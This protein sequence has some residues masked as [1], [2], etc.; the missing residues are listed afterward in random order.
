MFAY[1]RIVACL[2]LCAVFSLTSE[3]ASRVS[4]CVR[5]EV[6]WQLGNA[7]PANNDILLYLPNKSGKSSELKTALFARDGKQVSRE[8]AGK[9]LE[10]RFQSDEGNGASPVA[11]LLEKFI[12]T[13]RGRDLLSGYHP[14]FHLGPSRANVSVRDVSLQVSS[15]QTEVSAVIDLLEVQNA[16]SRVD[17]ISKGVGGLSLPAVSAKSVSPI[18]VRVPV[19]VDVSSEGKVG[20]QFHELPH[21][22]VSNLSVEMDGAK[23]PTEKVFEFLHE[24]GAVSKVRTQLLD[25]LNTQVAQQLSREAK[26]SAQVVHP[27]TGAPLLKVEISP[28]SLTADSKGLTAGIRARINP[29]EKV[30]ARSIAK[31][32]GSSAKFHCP[33]GGANGCPEYDGA[34][35]VNQ[36]L[37]QNLIG[38]LY[39]SGAMSGLKAGDRTVSL[40][41]P[42]KI[43]YLSS[44]GVESAETSDHAAAY[45]K[46]GLRVRPDHLSGLEGMVLNQNFSIRT[47]VSL[48]AAPSKDGKGIEV[49]VLGANVDKYAVNEAGLRGPAR[50]L[51][52]LASIAPSAV[53]DT[54]QNVV[55]DAINSK[56]RNLA[57][58]PP[59]QLPLPKDASEHLG[60]VKIVGI[61]FDDQNNLYFLFK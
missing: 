13:P 24:T 18:T 58:L 45:V 59:V 33:I 60:S 49:Q 16:S 26:H 3:A 35:A 22:D 27:L 7:E 42:P 29:E 48:K 4:E 34:I 23:I 32:A 57:S 50:M 8:I 54:V 21:V 61:Q 9:D 31:S 36:S 11:A 44:K 56:L 43:Q 39:E 15:N 40:V 10:V 5:T 28:Q 12:H 2:I 20:F 17:L 41:E 1:L 53:S 38:H 37:I 30:E 51:A 47:E 6:F 52:K 25:F 19:S 55:A 46:V 14:S